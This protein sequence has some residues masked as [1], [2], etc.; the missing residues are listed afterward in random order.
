M[1]LEQEYKEKIIP[2]L[3]EKLGLKNPW[4]CPRPEKV[5][6]NVGVGKWVGSDAS[7]REE[8]LK[9]ISEDLSH[10]TGQRPQIT[11]A[12]KSI[13][14]FSLR[15]GSPVG[16]KVTLRGKR[17]YYF[18]ERLIH[19]VFPRIRDFQGIK[20]SSVDK[21]GNLT[22]GLEEQ[23]IFP[24]ISPEKTNIFFGMEITITTT[25]RNREEGIELL[26]NLGVPFAS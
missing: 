12:R 19:L 8:V 25:A 7:K 13:S 24:E 3:K 6:I 14:G 20:V 11:K 26:R 5:V 4:E 18:L 23:L 2:K 22:V 21:Q 9:S 15:E 1:N 16:L 17:M 10:I